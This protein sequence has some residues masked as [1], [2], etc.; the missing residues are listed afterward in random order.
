MAPLLKASENSCKAK[1]C[2][3]RKK[4]IKN[5]STEAIPNNGKNNLGCNT[6]IPCLNETTSNAV[7]VQTNV[8]SING[9]KTSFGLCEPLAAR[10]A[11]IETGINVNPAACSARN[12]S[13]ASVA[14]SFRNLVPANF[15]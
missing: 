8:E 15:A 7:K 4:K 12:I 1:G 9:I 10:T 6:L 5:A 11:S 14:L 2:S 3:V 13:C